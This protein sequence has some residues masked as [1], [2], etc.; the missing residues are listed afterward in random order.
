MTPE[1]L[2]SYQLP[3]FDGLSSTDLANIPLAVTEQRVQAWQTI[4]DQQDRSFG[5]YFLLSGRL[6]AVLH[7]PDGREIVISRFSTGEYFGEL[8]AIDGLPRSLAVLAKTD[9]TLLAMQRTTFLALFDAVPAIRRKVAGGL[10]ARIRS[11]TERNVEMA[12]LSVEQRV[13]A[14]ILRL[15]A[16]QGAASPGT[17]L[18]P[19]PTHAEIAGYIGTS[20]EMVSRSISRLS[21]QGVISAAR[22]RIEI[23]DPD[24]MAEL[25]V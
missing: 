12:T 7:T 9:A 4:F 5:L 16:G 18:D 8:A 1:Q 6:L 17:M 24:A 2:L 25:L 3:L 21:R 14:Y 11:L 19:A 15:A 20:R 22:Q 13:C 23:V 10:A